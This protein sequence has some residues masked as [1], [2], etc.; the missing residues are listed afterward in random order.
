MTKLKRIAAAVLAAGMTLS[1]FSGC[2]RQ[3]SESNSSSASSTAGSNQTQT[4]EEVP[5]NFN[6]TG[7]PIVN[8][9]ITVSIMGAK[10]AAQGEW[11]TLEVFKDL[12][13]LTNIYFSYDT[14]SRDVIQEKRSL[15]FASG[16]YPEVFFGAYITEQEEVKYGVDAGNLIPL[17]G[18]IEQYAPNIQAMFE[19]RPE[20]KK[21]ITA[22]DGHI[23][24]LPNV[25]AP[26]TYVT[27]FW[28]NGDWLKNLGITEDQLPDTL[29]GYYD[30][31]KRFQTEDPNGN[32]QADELPMCFAST[33]ETS[34]V[35]VYL[36]PAFGIANA[37][38]YAEDGQ[39][40]F[41]MLH[42][43]YPEFVKYV[44]R[45]YNEQIIDND[46]FTMD[47]ATRVAKGKANL[48]GIAN[49][50]LPQAVW[51]VNDPEIAKT[52]YLAPPLRSEYTGNEPW[53]R[54]AATGIRKGAFSI[55]DK[56]QNPEAMIRYVDYLYS[57]EG[58]LLIH[59]GKEGN[60]WEYTPEGLMT[61]IMPEDG[62][63]VEEYRAGVITP[64]SGTWVPKWVRPE[65]E[66]NW[67][68]AFQ[69]Y[70]VQVLDEKMI[71]Y[72]HQGLP[73]MYFTAEEQ[74]QADMLLLDIQK[75]CDEMESKFF[76]GELDIETEYD[77]FVEGLKAVGIEDMLA[78][79]QVSYE[80]WL[81]A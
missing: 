79:Y 11:D 78:L 29:D 21:S 37:R 22:T 34:D 56:C 65:T 32:G 80:R 8:D 74:S 33:G 39:I 49:T 5:D 42:E 57:E 51:D 20:I 6:P 26:I 70:R 77:A 54:Q 23:Y 15:A 35:N 41:G 59:Y 64:D 17:D 81:E 63:T 46:W 69:Q 53:V 4:A 73:Q 16:T 45:L 24:C 12:E 14:P 55:T 3:E 58:S 50:S 52:Y 31:M 48:I 30:L 25:S 44:N 2:S 36:L 75:Y 1:A 28:Y 13:E 66:A 10:N 67:D 18:L 60:L 71:P 9:P 7:F 76:V 68:D 27:S 40:K 38:F 19:E 43:N 72:I 61:Y 47:A 62:R